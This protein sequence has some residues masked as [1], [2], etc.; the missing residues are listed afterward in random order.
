[1][2]CWHVSL[3]PYHFKFILLDII[4]GIL[5]QV[6]DDGMFCWHV[7]LH[8]Y[9]FKFILLDIIQEILKQVQD[10]GLGRN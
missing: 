2:F 3:H 4:Q 7:S 8:P 9:H 5:K 1:M 10:D 6:Q